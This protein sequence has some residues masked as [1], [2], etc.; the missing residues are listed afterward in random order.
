M[1]RLRAFAAPLARTPFHPQWLLGARKAPRSIDLARGRILDVGAGD[2]W[3]QAHLSQDVHYVALDYPTTGRD[4]YGAKPD[5]FADA[6]HLPFDDGVF[7]AV[8]CLEVLEHVRA[9]Q[10]VLDEIARVLRPGG[11]VWLSMPFLYPIHDAP[12]D[13]QRF[14]QYGLRRDVEASGLGLLEVEKTLHALR[15]AGLLTCLAIAGGAQGAPRW[16]WPLLLPVT[17]LAIVAVNLGSWL[18]SFL[19]PDW[20]A[21][22]AGYVLKAVKP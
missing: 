15:T 1:S 8:I 4:M 19:W 20:E 16:Q 6:A 22:T 3:I 21:L 12:H 17:L 14:T 5:V 13:Y 7:D 10:L 9:P 2:R 11:V 18:A